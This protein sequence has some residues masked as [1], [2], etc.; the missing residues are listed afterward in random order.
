MR[1]VIATM[2]DG[3]P[4]YPVDRYFPRTLRQ[5]VP[6]PLPV[7]TARAA[8][9]SNRQWTIHSHHLRLRISHDIPG[10]DPRSCCWLRCIGAARRRRGLARRC[11]RPVSPRGRG[12]SQQ[13]AVCCCHRHTPTRP[14]PRPKRAVVPAGRANACAAQAYAVV[15]CCHLRF[16][17]VPSLDPR[18][19]AGA[20]ARLSSGHSAGIAHLSQQ[21]RYVKGRCFGCPVIR[22][23]WPCRRDAATARTGRCRRCAQRDWRLRRWLTTRCVR[24]S[25]A[26]KSRTL[27]SINA[28]THALR[29]SRWLVLHL[30]ACCRALRGRL[31]PYRYI[32][33][34][35]SCSWRSSP[36]SSAGAADTYSALTLMVLLKASS[37]T[38]THRGRCG[39]RAGLAAQRSIAR[40]TCSVWSFSTLPCC[41]LQR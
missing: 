32:A 34:R 40:H 18:R 17:P 39:A 21:L 2:V 4:R 38:Q 12:C 20:V 31:C 7:L 13:S 19:A 36:C 37:A 8:D 41:L 25:S 26:P 11:E 5:T 28:S 33:A 35:A 23:D 10:L 6:T 29:T 1:C 30:C 3:Q 22:N 16:A 9:A 14:L 27:V 24:C 15:D